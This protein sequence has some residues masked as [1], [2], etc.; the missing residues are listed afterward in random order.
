MQI[1]QI[2]Y[3]RLKRQHLICQTTSN[4]V[5]RDLCGLQA[6]YLSHALHALSVRTQ[7]LH[8]DDMVKTWTLRGTMHLITEEDLPL[9]LYEGR[10]HFLRPMDTM[11]TDE[12]VTAK[13]KAYFASRLNSFS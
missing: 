6:Q 5:V 13:R 7:K 12:F 8:T 9:F 1:E 2:R 4:T 11:D 10:S 3:L